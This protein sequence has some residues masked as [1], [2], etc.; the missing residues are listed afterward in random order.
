MLD[1]FIYFLIF[2]WEWN[3]IYTNIFATKNH[4]VIKI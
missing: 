3:I 4:K 1:A 2:F